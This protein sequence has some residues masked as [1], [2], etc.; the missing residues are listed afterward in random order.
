MLREYIVG[1]KDIVAD[2]KKELQDC[3]TACEGLLAGLANFEPA[4]EANMGTEIRKSTEAKTATELY[5]QAKKLY[6]LGSKEKALE[7]LKKAQKLYEKCLQKAEKAGKMY[8]VERTAKNT[9]GAGIGGQYGVE[10]KYK[11][12]VTDKVDIAY[13]IDYFEDR[14]DSCKALEMQWNNKA[15]KSTFKETKAQLRLE[16]R[17]ALAGKKA[18][19]KAKHSA[20]KYA[21]GAYKAKMATATTDEEREAVESMFDVMYATEAFADELLMDYDLSYALEAEGD[22]GTVAAVSEN[23]QKLRDLYT[24][25]NEAKAAGDEAKM[26]QLVGEIQKVLDAINKEAQDAYTEDDMKAADRKL[27]KGLAI[28]AAVVAA[29][30]AIGVGVKT[31]A[32]AKVAQSAKELAAKLKTNKG[33]NKGETGKA[34]GLMN[35]LKTALS[36]MK[37]KIKLGKKS[38]GQEEGPVDAVEESLID[39]MT[40]EEFEASMESLMDSIELD[41]AMEAAME[42]EGEEGETAKSASGIGAKLRAAFAKLK[43]AKKEDDSTAVAEAEREVNEAAEEL[44]EAADAAETPEEKAKV[45]KALKIGLAAAATAA[46]AVGLGVIAA[47]A[48]KGAEAKAAKGFELNSGEKLLRSAASAIKRAKSTASQVA[49]NVADKAE[50]AGQYA[51]NRQLANQFKKTAFGKVAKESFLTSLAFGLEG[52]MVEGEDV[53]DDKAEPEEGKA[54]D[55][56]D[57][58]EEATEAA[59]AVMMA[60]DGIDDSD[61]D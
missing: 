56:E 31:G 24:Q 44:G 49:G 43:K 5:K 11:K 57:L 55:D 28:G 41:L 54:F 19:L 6:G 34:K 20:K 46:A 52:V 18:E 39:G 59:I 25:F 21:N 4:T 35:N 53:D 50:R 14:I 42:S 7:Y 3:P 10:D 47:K 51:K 58:I 9:I 2:R 37:G 1:C 48:S 22:E 13:V 8:E 61:L 32:F 26:N 29:A 60:E 33:E 17:K 36:G 27:A 16:R 40:C 45:G 23:E 38:D 15:G 12:N 30:A